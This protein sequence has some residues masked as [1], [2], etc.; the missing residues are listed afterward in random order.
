MRTINP[1]GEVV[2]EERIALLFHRHFRL[3]GRSHVL[4]AVV[5]RRLHNYGLQ[6]STVQF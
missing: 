1:V 2:G 3:R 6:D 4:V 5:R